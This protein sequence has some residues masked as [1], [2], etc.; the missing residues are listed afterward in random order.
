M[1]DLSHTPQS[2]GSSTTGASPTQPIDP[3]AIY[4]QSLPINARPAP[5]VIHATTSPVGSDGPTHARTLKGVMVDAG[6]IDDIF[7]MSVTVVRTTN[8]DINTDVDVTDSFKITPR[9]FQSLTR[10]PRLTHTTS[11]PRFYSG[12]LS[13]SQA[14]IIIKI[15]PFSRHWQSLS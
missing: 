4:Q 2:L 15:Q 8:K 10:A 7:Q 5:V 12:Q 14:G 1:T 9:F 3:L 6:E 13:S 11:N